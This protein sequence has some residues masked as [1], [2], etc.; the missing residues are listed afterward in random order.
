MPTL[1]KLLYA[2][3]LL[4]PH[5]NDRQVRNG[6]EGTRAGNSFLNR[7]VPVGSGRHSH[8]GRSHDGAP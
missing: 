5:L 1:K 4:T 6:K 8:D 3:S 7:T 2:A